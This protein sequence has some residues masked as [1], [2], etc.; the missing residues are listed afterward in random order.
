[1]PWALPLVS[2]MN[3]ISFHHHM[4]VD[5]V[6]GMMRFGAL[7]ACVGAA[8]AGCT[9]KIN[10]AACRMP[11]MAAPPGMQCGS[12]AGDGCLATNMC[13]C[14]HSADPAPQPAP[15]PAPEPVVCP[16]CIPLPCPAPYP[17]CEYMPPEQDQCGCDIGCGTSMCLGPGPIIAPPPPPIG[18]TSRCWHCTTPGTCGEDIVNTDGYP[19]SLYTM[20]CDDEP[21]PEPAPLS[22]SGARY[23]KRTALP[24]CICLH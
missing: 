6:D 10:A 5:T 14:C 16:R 19:G 11:C 12:D 3:K 18:G 24:A 9:G 13:G 20:G 7:A 8:A 22:Q 17:G 2:R 4:Y 23:P 21:A 15:E 1:M